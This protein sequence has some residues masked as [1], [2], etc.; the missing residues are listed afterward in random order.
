MPI[1]RPSSCCWSRCCYLASLQMQS[2]QASADAAYAVQIAQ[3]VQKYLKQLLA[4][5]REAKSGTQNS[6]LTL[7]TLQVA[8][9]IVI[10][11]HGQAGRLLPSILALASVDFPQVSKGSIHKCLKAGLLPVFSSDIPSLRTWKLKVHTLKICRGSL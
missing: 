4:V 2:L 1:T 3:Q 6:L 10:L 7:A 8:L 11:R 5:L 9:Q